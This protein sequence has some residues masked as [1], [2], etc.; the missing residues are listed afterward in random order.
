LKFSATFKKAIKGTQ[1][2][3]YVWVF[4]YYFDISNFVKSNKNLKFEEF[5]CHCFKVVDTVWKLPTP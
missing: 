2:L 5:F 1:A 3:T 4:G